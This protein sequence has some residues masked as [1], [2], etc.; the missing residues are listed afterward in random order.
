M[1]KAKELISVL[2]NYDVG[3]RKILKI[4]K[5]EGQAYVVKGTL[6][7]INKGQD[8]QTAFINACDNENFYG[9]RPDVVSDR[10]EI[11]NTLKKYYKIDVDYKKGF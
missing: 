1:S 3:W 7:N 8:K 9:M 2:E 4:S 6:D 11:A 5:N 10:K